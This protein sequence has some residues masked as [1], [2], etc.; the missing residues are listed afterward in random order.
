MIL[1]GLKI[2]RHVPDKFGSYLVTGI[3]SWFGVQAFV[4]IGAMVGIMPITGVP[5]PFLSYGGTALV[6]S[7]AAAGIVLN[8]SKYAKKS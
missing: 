6:V 5:L 1:Q 7:M 3:V 2:A 8:V 4:N